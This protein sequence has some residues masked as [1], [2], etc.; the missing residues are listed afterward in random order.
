MSTAD[1]FL[2]NLCSQRRKQLSYAIAPIRFELQ[3]T[4]YPQYTQSQLNMRRKVE[5][6]KYSANK[7][8]SKTN[9]FTKAERWSQ[10]VKGYYNIPPTKVITDCQSDDL[11]P[12]LTTASDVPGPITYLQEDSSVPLYNFSINRNIYA[13][14]QSTQNPPWNIITQNDI[15]FQAGVPTKLF[16]LY[17][18]ESINKPYY[19][20]TFQTP[21]AI[22]ISASNKRSENI[23]EKL[24]NAG[25][26]I[27]NITPTIYY[28]NSIVQNQNIIITPNISSIVD[29]SYNII[30][31]RIIYCICIFRNAY[32]FKYC[33]K[34]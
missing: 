31:I 30:C 19:N 10:L 33:I 34:Y 7:T 21:F 15:F 6:L 4:P 3:T 14:A 11:I 1:T 18:L 8:N 27:A 20:F 5:I 29:L 28:S 22:Y 13:T 16:S 17:I 9:K 25:L 23:D 2:N 32:H 26:S 24:D 12:T